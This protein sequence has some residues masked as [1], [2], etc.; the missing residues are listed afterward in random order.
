MGGVDKHLTVH[1]SSYLSICP[2]L[3]FIFLICFSVHSMFMGGW[4]V[5]GF[6]CVV[7]TLGISQGASQLYPAWNDKVFFIVDSASL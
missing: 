4:G 7:V 6:L 1:V 5:L 3:K 2:Y